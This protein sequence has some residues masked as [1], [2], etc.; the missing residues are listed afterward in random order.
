MRIATPSADRGQLKLGLRSYELSKHLGNILAVITDN[1]NMT[2]NTEN[3]GWYNSKAWASVLTTNDYYPFGLQ[4]AGRT[5]DSSVYRY[6]FNGKEIDNW[7]AGEQQAAVTAFGPPGPPPAPDEPI[8]DSQS[9]MVYDYGFRIY[10]PTIGKFLSVDPLT[11][12]Y[13]MLTPYQ[14]ASNRPIDGV[15]L[16][17]LEYLRA[18]EA[19]IE[20]VYG[21]LF[22][23]LENF[24]Q[25]YQ[26]MYRKDNPYTGLITRDDQG[27]G[28]GDGKIGSVLK[29]IKIK[30]ARLD[31]SGAK[32]KFY[33]EGITLKNTSNSY[34]VRN[35]KI[36]NQQIVTSPGSAKGAAAFTFVVNAINFTAET[37]VNYALNQENAQLANQINDGGMMKLGWFIAEDEWIPYTSP[38]TK[39]LSIVKKEMGEG[40]LI[41]KDF[42]NIEDL[43]SIINIL[44][45]GGKGNER[46]EVMEI[47]NKL[48]DDVCEC[49]QNEIEVNK[50]N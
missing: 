38:L 15:D 18:D 48:I 31:N 46:K 45:F 29:P 10:N 47:G 5:A 25:L 50:E 32:P 7:S 17:G 11:K 34:S 8:A 1:V 14:F 6:G 26:K 37:Y 39:A 2:T 13:P 24:S 40:G 16:D 36:T 30:T 21:T 23:K 9:A 22:I 44:L 49:R 19:R 41:T 12:S 33:A 27:F 4:M 35:N 3:S 43:S 20:V 28:N 42:Q